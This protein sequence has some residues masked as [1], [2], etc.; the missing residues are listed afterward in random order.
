MRTK[1]NEQTFFCSYLITGSTK[2]GKK[3]STEK[4]RIFEG[5]IQ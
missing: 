3:F 2:G 1:K 5:D 4:K